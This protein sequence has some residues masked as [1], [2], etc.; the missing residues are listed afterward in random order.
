MLSDAQVNDG[1]DILLCPVTQGNEQLCKTASKFLRKLSEIMVR[2]ESLVSDYILCRRT[3][4]TS[5][6]SD[7]FSCLVRIS[8]RSKV[9]Q[10]VNVRYEEYD[11]IFTLM[12]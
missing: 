1:C 3:E 8:L 9:M 7:G 6:T 12:T 5:E 2:L 10:L 11:D 4:K